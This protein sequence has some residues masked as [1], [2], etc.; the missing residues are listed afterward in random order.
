LRRAGIK[1]G[2]NRDRPG[3]TD[4]ME[5]AIGLAVGVGREIELVVEGG[6]EGNQ[7][8]ETGANG[9]RVDEEDLDPFGEDVFIDPDLAPGGRYLL[10][11]EAR[12]LAA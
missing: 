1:E 8:V 12:R 3:L 9:N 4:P 11:V 6:R 5:T 10:G 7:I 2:L